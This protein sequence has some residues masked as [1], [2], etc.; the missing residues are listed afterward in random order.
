VSAMENKDPK[1]KIIPTTNGLKALKILE[2]D[3]FDLI[4]IDMLM[5]EM[6]GHTLLT[7][8]IQEYKVE[9]PIIVITA[10][11][12]TDQL[13]K[14]VDAGAYDILQK[15]FTTNR[16]NLTLRN[17]LKYLRLTKMCKELENISGKD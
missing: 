5:P 3:D 13:M 7:K 12:A 2:N 15:P 8:M 1:I 9:A 16:L 17:A 14:M 4:L 6:D 10:H 11:G